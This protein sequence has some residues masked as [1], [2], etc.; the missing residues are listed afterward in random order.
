MDILTIENSLKSTFVKHRLIFWYDE[1]GEWREAFDAVSDIP[2]TKL[3]VNNNEFGTKVRILRDDAQA[4]YLLYFS[5]AKPTDSENWLLDL[6]RM[7]REFKPD[8]VTLLLNEA[9][10]ANDFRGIVEEHIKFFKSKKRIAALKELLSKHDDEKSIRLKMLAVLA[11]SAAQLD[12]ILLT[13][14]ASLDMDSLID[15]AGHTFD[16]SNLTNY[17]WEQ[18]GRDFGYKSNDP[19][20]RDFV[21][22]LFRRANPL[23]KEIKPNAHSRVFLQRWKDHVKY[24]AVFQKWSEI[25]QGQLYIERSLNNH[26]GAIDLGDA[27][28]FELFE[29]YTLHQLCDQFDQG[30]TNTKLESVLQKRRESLWWDKYADGYAAIEKAVEMRHLLDAFPSSMNSVEEGIKLYIEAGWQID[31]AYRQSIFHLSNYCEPQLMAQIK[32]WVEKAYLADFLIPLCDQWSMY[33]RNMI[34]WD[35]Q[36]VSPQRQFF[37]KYVQPFRNKGQKVVVIV[38][39]A[40][41]YEAARELAE[42]L[43]A[44][45]AWTADMDCL[46]AS[47][48]SYT[49]LGMASL[50]PINQLSLD[51]ETKVVKTDGERTD[52]IENRAGILN[53]FCDGK[54]TAIAAEKFLELRSVKEGRPLMRDN[55]VIFVY[56]NVIDNEG[57]DIKTEAKTFGA[58]DRAFRELEEIA[59]KAV[60]INANNVLIT[61]DHGFLFQQ[62]IVD[63][64]DDILLPPAQKWQSINR[65]FAIGENITSAP[66]IK[67]F[68]AANLGLQGNWTAAFPC[69]IGR[70][71]VKGSGKRYVHGG[72][73]LQ[74]VI[75]PVIKLHRERDGET[76]EAE[77][78]LQSP[79]SMI[80]SESFPVTLFQKEA[81]EGKVLPRTVS[82]GIFASDNTPL[83]DVRTTTFDSPETE[84]R[85]RE[86]RI[87]LTLAAAADMFNNSLVELRLQGY[88]P[89]ASEPFI[90]DRRDVKIQRLF[91]SDFN[92]F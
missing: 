37:Q 79:P 88:V 77:V 62:D 63:R 55:E 23:D 86:K 19:E 52:G 40:L 80:T 73:S 82:I 58:V 59:N 85:R 6:L 2:A 45:K 42:T 38:S 83:S 20:V 25:L 51:P 87:V 68:P 1:K 90:L 29:K 39:D 84:A 32:S 43:H 65:R 10:L 36:A 91:T 31:R 49:Q 70:F 35:C 69:S 41:R 27:D 53:R 46:F 50:L 5:S 26:D 14:I 17:F 67:L 64:L 8:N 54:A 16:D 11:G 76:R 56:H 44:R 66:G 4:R 48:P 81:V 3:E 24:R 28:T 74:E 12:D 34:N 92:E 57:D 33:V 22:M 71:P 47:L 60:A 21:V 78:I 30:L 89:G 15:P 61:A 18:V 75:I 7:G 13:L 72:F 9:E